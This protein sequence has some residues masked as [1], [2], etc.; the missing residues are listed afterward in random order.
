MKRIIFNSVQLIAVLALATPALASK[1]SKGRAVGAGLSFPSSHQ[2]INVNSSALAEADK[3]SLQG[4]WGFETEE[5]SVSLV[6]S[7]KSFGWGLGWK[8]RGTSNI[9]DAGLGFDFGGFLL[10]TN[11]YT[12][13]FDGVNG[14]VTATIDF[15]SFRIVTGF[16]GID[17]GVQRFDL[18]VGFVVNSLLISLDMYKALPWGDSDVYGFDTSVAYNAGKVSF[19]VGYDFLYFEGIQEGEIH[20]DMSVSVA[21]NFAIE[22]HYRLTPWHGSFISKFSAGA[23]IIF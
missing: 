11:F 23:R 1:G 4:L 10:G 16:R 12:N 9:F 8:D 18:G 19:G 5:P 13:D 14:D 17:D 2:S 15:S 21:S 7:Q 3:M 20:G 6:G 22:G